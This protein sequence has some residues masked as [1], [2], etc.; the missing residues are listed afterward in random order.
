MDSF[1]LGGGLGV[2]L[3]FFFFL[4]VLHPCKKNK[5][6][7]VAVKDYNISKFFFASVPN[8]GYICCSKEYLSLQKYLKYYK[9]CFKTMLAQIHYFSKN[10]AAY[11]WKFYKTVR[12]HAKTE[13][14]KLT[15]PVRVTE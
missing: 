8:F 12:N 4:M 6:A 5:D 15:F 13:S 7:T 2:F 1:F 11:F 14:S 10:C 3:D 9:N